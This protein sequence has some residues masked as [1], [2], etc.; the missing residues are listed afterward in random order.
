MCREY[1]GLTHSSDCCLGGIL[2]GAVGVG[3][4][5]LEEWSCGAFS[6]YI[7]WMNGGF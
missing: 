5:V 1:I 4:V 3:L 6:D 7:F 2:A